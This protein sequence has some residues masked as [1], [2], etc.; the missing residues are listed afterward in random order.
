MRYVVSLFAAILVGAG[1]GVLTGLGADLL[2]RA[3]GKWPDVY[4]Y[5]VGAG[6]GLL[7]SGLVAMLG[8]GRLAAILRRE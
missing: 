7:C 4:P 6:A 3:A 8:P 1:V 5:W 2:L